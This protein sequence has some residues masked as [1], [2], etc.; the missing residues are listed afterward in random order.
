[1]LDGEENLKVS[2]SSIGL[3]GRVRACACVC[4]CVNATLPLFPN[5][6]LKN[7]ERTIFPLPSIALLLPFLWFK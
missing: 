2:P 1:M 4:V 6:I 5:A 3:R 7:I